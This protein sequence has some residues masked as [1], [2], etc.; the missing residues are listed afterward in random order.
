AQH[1]L[2]QLYTVTKIYQDDESTAA[3]IDETVT[4][5]ST[6]FR[7]LC[8][9]YLSGIIPCA[10]G[11]DGIATVVITD[12]NAESYGGILLRIIKVGPQAKDFA[13][14]TKAVLKHVPDLGQHLGEDPDQLAVLPLKTCGARWSRTESSRSSTWRERAAL[15]CVVHDCQALLHGKCI[16]LVDNINAQR[17]WNELESEFSTG[18]YL[19]RWQVCQRHIHSYAWAPRDALPAIADAI[20]RSI[21]CDPIPSCVAQVATSQATA[22]ASPPGSPPANIQLDASHLPGQDLHALFR[23]WRK[24]SSS[25]PFEDHDDDFDS[26]QWLATAQAECPHL[27]HL[28]QAN[29]TKYQL[30]DAGLLHVNG[31]Y[32]VPKCY[33]QDIVRRIHEAYA[34][35]GTAQCM[36][37]I[38][39]VFYVIGLAVAVSK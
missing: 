32:M 37:L 34:H 12:A 29:P 18:K 15:L 14:A 8:D 17:V 9:F 6:A 16:A 27:Q 26:L 31:R 22:V 7:V 5:V 38:S 35:C 2:N 21:A 25:K 11:N 28:R 3:D 24:I 1:A 36:S 4:V 23:H 39:S 13:D 33:G 20:A 10:L 30:N 19:T